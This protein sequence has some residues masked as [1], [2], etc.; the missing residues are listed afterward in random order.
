MV[1]DTAP[2][3][4]GT[5]CLAVP[6]DAAKKHGIPVRLRSADDPGAGHSD[7]FWMRRVAKDHVQQMLMKALQQASSGK[8]NPAWEAQLLAAL[9]E[10]QAETA[11]SE[12]AIVS[13]AL[14]KDNKKHLR[15]AGNGAVDYEAGEGPWG[16]FYANPTPRGTLL[17]SLA[18]PTVH[19]FVAR[20]AA[21]DADGAA[22]FQSSRGPA[23]MSLPQPATCFEWGTVGPDGRTPVSLMNGVQVRFIHVPTGRVMPRTYRAEV[24]QPDH[25]AALFAA[26]GNAHVGPSDWMRAA[27]LDPARSLT[28][29]RAA[30]FR[31]QVGGGNP[32]AARLG[33]HAARQAAAQPGGRLRITGE[34][35]VDEAGGQGP[36]ATWKVDMAPGAQPPVFSLQCV[37]HIFAGSRAFL[38]AGPNTS[39]F[40]PASTVPHA[41]TYQQQ[42]QS[43]QQAGHGF[44][45]FV[46]KHEAT[47]AKKGAKHMS[48]V[49]KMMLPR[50]AFEALPEAHDAVQR[51]LMGDAN[52]FLFFDPAAAEAVLPAD[53]RRAFARD[54]FITLDRAVAR[55]VVDAARHFV[56]NLLGK[57]PGAWEEDPEASAGSTDG[58]K[59]KL[60]HG[61][62]HT[63]LATIYQ[64]T[65]SS[66][67]QQLMGGQGSANAVGGA[68]LAIRFPVDNSVPKP[69]DDA[70][71][72]GNIARGTAAYGEPAPIAV[73]HCGQQGWH[74]D[75][76]G[77][78]KMLPFGLLVLVALSDQSE[79]GHGNFT[80]WPGEHRNPAVRTWYHSGRGVRP[81]N[82]AEVTQEQR[83]RF[84]E[85]AA[86]K[87]RL[88]STPTQ[89]LLK[90]GDVALVHPLLPH[91][92]GVNTSPDPRY[93]IIMRFQSAQQED[94]EEAARAD[95]LFEPFSHLP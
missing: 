33:M 67:I 46:P 12:T 14:L 84:A 85:F 51:I 9:E 48:D 75:G 28:E 29:Q 40:D 25:M 36:W 65:V 43:Q 20:N 89:V 10:V 78:E 60:K 73:Q 79:E 95:P 44:T 86:R 77:R 87:P 11:D 92:V 82:E 4:L 80:V 59:F 23:R 41:P 50:W 71:P 2:S 91:S 31:F 6:T 3:G 24:V 1:A 81:S 52:S 7:I 72:G 61:N 22:Y 18:N 53:K 5:M 17:R 8:A 30:F 56:N 49:E 54:G 42:A 76:M 69:S 83:A 21:K 70:A 74:I 37:G 27:D 55:R 15:V 13:F 16:M 34:G 38:A 62:H 88:A 68:Q 35:V 45:A 47:Q 19:R 58:P 90:A 66:A 64:S 32:V 57:G 94:H 93:T 63:L 39:S 26:A